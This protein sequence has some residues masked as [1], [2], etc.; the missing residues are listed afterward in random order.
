MTGLPTLHDLIPLLPELVLACGAM[1]ML[2]LGVAIGERSSAVV[3]GF[4]FIVLLLAGAALSFVPSWKR[5]SGRN[6]SRRDAGSSRRGLNLPAWRRRH[7][8]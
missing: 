3:N 7:G 2:M 1:A 8:W 5:A 6:R 4:C